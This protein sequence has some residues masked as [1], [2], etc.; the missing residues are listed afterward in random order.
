MAT[1]DSLPGEGDAKRRASDGQINPLTDTDPGRRFAATPGVDESTVSLAQLRAQSES[2]KIADD[3]AFADVFAPE[4]ESRAP[5]RQA[6]GTAKPGKHAAARRYEEPAKKASFG[7]AVVWTVLG[8]IL[9]GVGLIKAGR[10]VVGVIILVLFLGAAGALGALAVTNRRLLYTYA[11]QSSVLQGVAVGLAAL[12][13]VMVLIIC[14]SHLALRPKN[15]SLGQRLGGAVVVGILSLAITAPMAI[16][17]NYAYTT[18]TVVNSVFAETGR[19]DNVPTI[20]PEVDPWEQIPRLNILILGGDSGTGRSDKLG[21][22]ADTVIVASIDTKTGDTTLFSLPRNTARMPFPKDSPLYKYYPNGFY[23]G[24]DG[25]NAEYFLNAMYRNVPARV[26]KNILGKTDNLAADVMKISVSEALGLDIDYYI[27]VNMDGFKQLI[28]ALG[29]VTLNVNYRIPIGGKTDQKV[30]PRDWIEVGPNQLMKGSRA[31]WYARG[32]YGLN[33]YSR[34]ERQRC[35][36]NAVVHQANPA[37]VL[38]RF[39]AVAEAGKNMVLTD[40]PQ[41]MLPAF[42]ELATRIQGTKM[43]SIVFQTGKDGWVSANPPWDKVKKRVQQA[44]KETA[45]ANAEAAQPTATA[46]PSVTPGKSTPTPTSTSKPK[47]E[48]LDDV[49]AYHPEKEK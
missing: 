7:A 5:R 14:A 41:D 30:P 8:T 20:E 39:N 28:N 1:D 32:R 35:V 49:C 25:K 4:G 38:A 3:P 46:T 10:K 43:R 33:D 26:P 29:G 6:E 37:N 17:A 15:P 45:K 42:V 31:L 47:S 40:V 2:D 16:G 36:I 18:S 19:S 27:V 23:D 48:D 34:M 12:G 21:M 9:P 11:T 22:R 24:K 13:L 44:I